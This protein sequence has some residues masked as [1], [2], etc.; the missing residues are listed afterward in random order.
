M[1]LLFFVV[2][3]TLTISGLCSLLEATL[4]STRAATLE[5]AVKSDRHRTAAR[6][7]L[8]LKEKISEPTSA[9][10]ILNTIANTAGATIAG[11]YATRVMG[12]VWIPLFSIALTFAI[13]FFSE[14]LPKT[15]GATHWRSVWTFV[16]WP[17]SIIVRVLRPLVR[18]TQG[19]AGVFTP[20]TVHPA[21]TQD[22]ILAMIHMG[23][24][25]GEVDAVA[26]QMLD[27]VF[28]LNRLRCRQV[29]VPRSEVVFFEENQPLA[30]CIALARRT[31]HTR[32]PL[33]RESLDD[34]IGIVHIKDLFGLPADAAVDLA[35]LARP[36]F[37]FPETKRVNEVLGEMRRS[38]RHMAVVLDEHGGTSGVVTLENLIETIVGS[39]E[40]EFDY[41]AP[42]I[43]PIG[44]RSYLVRG[45]ASLEH[46]NRELSLTLSGPDI[47]TLS[48]LL[49]AELGR[50]AEAGD[51]I[52]LAG[53][54][55]EVLTATANVAEKVRLTL[56]PPQTDDR[57][58]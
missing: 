39:V 53:A 56:H 52:P 7:F 49:S 58:R 17:L 55:A 32:Y 40:D 20:K 29:M 42:E 28:Q 43:V 24:R 48:G 38:R 30:E 51:R 10:L 22:E 1:T 45:R 21:V 18:A 5:A 2:A 27:S 50:F 35:T 14:I 23:A 16:V 25:S 6:R 3:L 19:F 4:Y 33:C 11:M 37:L 41:E 44:R 57:K 26:L 31:Q 12:G 13:L 36:A 47:N 8:Q 34:V 46:I 15:Y 9:I 54:D